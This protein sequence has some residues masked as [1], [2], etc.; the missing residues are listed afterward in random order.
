MFTNSLFSDYLKENGLRIWKEESTRDIVCLEFN[1]GSRSYDEEIKHLTKIAKSARIE[2][3][4]AKSN[5]HKTQIR[6]KENKRKK[7]KGSRF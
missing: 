2:Y 1:F 5:G 3:K 4:L 7:K 6:K